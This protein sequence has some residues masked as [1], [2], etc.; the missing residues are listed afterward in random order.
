MTT[1]D[2]FHNATDEITL[3]ERSLVHIA[4]AF[5]DTGNTVMSDK[6]LIQSDK[7]K[8]E[9]LKCAIRVSQPPNMTIR[10]SNMVQLDVYKRICGEREISSDDIMKM[11]DKLKQ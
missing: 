3:I 2:D 8:M 4:N 1:L 6:L 11:K 9:T 5:F 7:L 10:E